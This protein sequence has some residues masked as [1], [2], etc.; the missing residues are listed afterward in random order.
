MFAISVVRFS[1]VTVCTVDSRMN[2]SLG[3]QITVNTADKQGS[4]YDVAECGRNEI[5][6]DEI[7]PTYRSSLHEIAY[8]DN[9]PIFQYGHDS[10]FLL[11]KSGNQHGIITGEKFCPGQNDQDKSQR[12]HAT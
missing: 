2:L 1:S 9:R 3:V 10:V 11:H 6:Q 12:E 5:C 4:A 8:I 7:I